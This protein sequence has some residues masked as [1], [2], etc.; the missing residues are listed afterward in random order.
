MTE[1]VKV[2][3]DGSR[4]AGTLAHTWNYI[5][6][7]ECNYTH[8]PGGMA[9]LRKFGRLEKPYYVRAHHMLCTGNLH[10]TYKWGSTNVYLEDADGNPVYDFSLIDRMC[11][12]WLECNLK[13]FFELGFMPMHLADPRFWQDMRPDKR[14]LPSHGE[15]RR[16]GW[17]APPKDYDRWYDLILALT[18]HLLDRYGAQELNSWYFEMWNEPDIFYWL[19][20]HEEYCKMYDYA[21]KAIHDAL[22]TARFGGPAT[23]GTRNPQGKAAVF[24]RDFL[25][26][27]REGVNHATG[28][29]GARIDF[30]SFHTKGGG[31]GFTTD[32]ALEKTPSVK[33]LVEQVKVLGSIVKECGYG[34]LECVLSE[35]DPDG[36]AAGGRFDNPAFDFRNT[37]YY[38]SYVAS[39]YKNLYDLA[40]ELGMDIRPLA[41]AFMFEGERCFEGTR[42]FST[43]GID[44]AVFN[45]FK[46]LARLGGQRVAL[47]SS[48][49]I[50]PLE[51]P[52]DWGEG[53]GSEIDGWATLSGD[54]SLE[55]L[56][57]CHEDA[58]QP[59]GGYSVEFEAAGLPFGGQYTLRHYR[60]D[61]DH[62]N[63]YAEWVRQGRPD[64]PAAG[65]YAAIKRRDRLELL[66]PVRTEAMKDGKVKLRFDMPPQ[67]VSLLIIQRGED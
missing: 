25:L 45:T 36:W 15:Y 51:Y 1:T 55:V 40:D 20:T 21:E 4:W 2:S 7:D 42:T 19:G 30:T 33:S 6:Y 34:D 35:A 63:P 16:I 59:E 3:V 61:G 43:Q 62:S 64:Y 39:S 17:N 26:H 13:P 8:S 57:Y 38:A 52:N 66:E 12:I 46:L 54:S 32:A 28:A 23:T 9:L 24:L 31:Y 37:P 53:C 58:W 5:G 60:I 67:S 48:R 56:L 47:A 41:W 27:C 22:P 14:G 50:D 29:V 10:G 44:K 49:D 11:D 18:R 65:Q